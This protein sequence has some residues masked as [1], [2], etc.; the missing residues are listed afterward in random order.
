MQPQTNMSNP[1]S[2]QISPAEIAAKR[3]LEEMFECINAGQN[4]KLEA[5]AGAGKTF[6]LVQAL[7]LII[8]E[9]GPALQRS[10]QQVACITYTNVAT[11]EIISRTDGHPAIYASTIHAF[12]WGLIKSFQA[13]LR[14]KVAD[15]DAWSEKLVEA[16]GIGT[17]KVNYDLGYRRIRDDNLF[18]HHD[19]VLTLTVAMM[20]QPKFRQIL[21]SRFPILF[22]DEYQDTNA[23]FEDSIIEHFIGPGVGPLIGLFG[24]SW[25]K[26]YR[27]GKG[28][29][30]HDNLRQI[31]KQANFRSVP[32]VVDILNAIRT[33]LP[34]EV[35][36][37]DATGSV[38]VFHTN[39]WAGVR[40]GG[41]HWGGDLPAEDAHAYLE[42]LRGRLGEEGWDFSPENT[43]ILMLTH[44]VLAAEQNY[45]Q[46]L[47]A[48][49]YNDSVMKKEDP[50]IAFL[51]DTVEPA[52]VAFQ[53]GRFGDMFTAI[54]S[55]SVNIRSLDD[56]Q[57]WANSMSTLVE[58]RLNGTIGDV[59]DHLKAT[60]RPRLPDAVQRT[61]SELENS[62]PEEIA[63]SLTLTQ[64][65]K[66]HSIPYRE[67]ISLALFINNYT[68]FSTKHGVKGAEFDNVLV[69]LGRGWNHYNWNLFLEWF[70]DRY[71][72]NKAEAYVRNRNLFYVS[73]S[74]AKKRLALLFTQELS[75]SALATLCSWFGEENVNP[76]MPD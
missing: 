45:G 33:D 47:N 11:D 6:S 54:G 35:H 59:L 7:R 21:T 69:V 13:M 20:E 25:Q 37:P 36:D 53:E 8:D 74:R 42:G 12:C 10:N 43:K 40:R 67:L 72:G 60:H 64:I 28:V 58:L 55:R 26:I 2:A 15:I 22:I 14:E 4:F 34:Q 50:H 41:G 3:A 38:I 24:D 46:I 65:N 70:P 44:S 52:C 66:L 71:P 19:D 68:P 63:A 1:E 16:G 48:F 23:D 18:L 49:Q 57:L 62:T 61:E 75:A 5:G 51:V 17:R 9:H 27:D 31:G 29:V 56:K 39:N 73:C 30:E 32:D 76:Y